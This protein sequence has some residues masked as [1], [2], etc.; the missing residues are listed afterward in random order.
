[1]KRKRLWLAGLLAAVP[2]FGYVAVA[3]AQSFRHGDNITVA[4][5]QTVDQTIYAWGRTIDIAGTVNGDVICAGQNVT[6]TGTVNGDVICAG[7]NV[8]I[9]GSVA[10]DVR[11]AGQDVSVSGTVSHNLS[12]MGQNITLESS[13]NVNTDASIAGQDTTING[14]VGRD[15]AAAGESVTIDNKVGRNVQTAGNQLILGSNANI[16]GDVT[17]TSNNTINKAGSA[18]VA[19]TVTHKTPPQKASHI[20]Y[21]AFIRGTFWFAFY[22]F[23]AGLVMAMVLV[24]L[25]PQTFHRASQVAI[26]KPGKTFLIGLLSGILAPIILGVVFVTVLGIPL[27]ILGLLVWLA[28]LMLSW[29]FAAY[30]TG[31]LLMLRSTNALLIMLVGAIVLML[32]YFVPFLGALVSLVAVCFGLGIIVSHIIHLPRPHYHVEAVHVDNGNSKRPTKK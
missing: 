2:V 11:V 13:G 29:P 20:Q 8:H 15:V 10:G 1:M 30:Y 14:I 31:R 7:Q 9:S 18:K 16:A 26:D 28:I 4:Q 21:G 25:L 27:A 19:G 17:Y 3:H 5:N 6:V 12:A 32:L 22:L 23:A 24:L